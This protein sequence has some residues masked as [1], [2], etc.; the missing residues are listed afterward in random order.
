M[1]PSQTPISIHVPREGDDSTPFKVFHTQQQFQST[2]PVRGTTS[3]TT[4][5]ISAAVFQSTSPVRGTTSVFRLFGSIL[6]FQSTSPE[7]GTTQSHRFGR[8]GR[9]FQSTSPS[10]GTTISAG[11]LLEEYGISIHVPLTGDDSQYKNLPHFVVISIHV[12]LTG[13]DY[14]AHSPLAALR[15]F[16][17]R[18]P[19]GGRHRPPDLDRLIPQFQS[20]SPSRG[21]TAGVQE[22][23]EVRQF[24][25]TSPSR[26]TTWH[27]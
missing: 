19:H 13:D 20:T 15:N 21:T 24:Q 12:P 10:R 17:P 26:G 27:Q 23:V 1:P 3:W 11:A 6:P 14:T 8:I 4:V 22:L 2:S 25:S 16:N 7:R 9:V 5:C 18:P